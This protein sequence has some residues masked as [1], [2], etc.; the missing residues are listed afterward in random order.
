[1][2]TPLY[3][4]AGEKMGMVNLPDAVF[5]LPWNAAL[6][7]QVV[8]A[9]RTNKRA[10]TA[11]TK[12]RGEVS[13]GGKK[14]WK[15]KGTGRARHG[16]I[17]SPLWVGGGVTHGPRTER[18]YDQKVNKRMRR[19]ALFI[20]L[21]GKAQSGEIVVMEDISFPGGRTREAQSVFRAL[22]IKGGIA[23]MDGTKATTLVALPA[24]DALTVRALHNLPRV[25][26][27]EVRNVNAESVLGVKYVVIPKSSLP[28]LESL[29]ALR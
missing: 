1:M 25:Q 23:D 13:G 2:E 6:V 19:K 3:N 27:C 16:S 28:I 17:R 10:N 14:P 18:V 5:S 29:A 9:S 24:L 11:H 4:M 22:A 26:S 15:Q 21:S 20:S 12:D 7:K 8:E